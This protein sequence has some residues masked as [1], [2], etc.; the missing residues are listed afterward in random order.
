MLIL[1]IWHK[2]S[3]ASYLSFLISFLLEG[4]HG[5]EITACVVL[6]KQI[7]LVECSLTKNVLTD[8]FPKK[9]SQLFNGKGCSARKKL[10]STKKN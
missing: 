10:R 7:R 4:K 2:N 1:E 6:R 9:P 5:K 8:Y 3:T